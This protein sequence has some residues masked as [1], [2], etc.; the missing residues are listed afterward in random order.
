MFKRLNRFTRRWCPRWV[1]VF[2]RE[3]T[4]CS[5]ELHRNA[6]AKVRR[7]KNQRGRKWGRIFF[8][9]LIQVFFWGRCFFLRKLFWTTYF[10]YKIWIAMFCC[11]TGWQ[12]F[13]QQQLFLGNWILQNKRG[14]WLKLDREGKWTFLGVWSKGNAGEICLKGCTSN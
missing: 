8:K 4:H 1:Q 14:C 2:L 3:A 5:L 10:H 13:V 12:D 9:S 11:H 6:A 7:E